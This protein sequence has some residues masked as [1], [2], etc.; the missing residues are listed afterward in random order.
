MQIRQIPFFDD[1]AAMRLSWRCSCHV[2]LQAS[3]I[4]RRVCLADPPVSG[5]GPSGKPKHAGKHDL[6]LHRSRRL[7]VGSAGK[8]Y[9]SFG[10]CQGRLPRRGSDHRSESTVDAAEQRAASCSRASIDQLR[11]SNDYVS[12]D[13]CPGN[14]SP[15]QQGIPTGCAAS[16][17]ARFGEPF[18]HGRTV[19][20]RCDVTLDRRSGCHR[21]SDSWPRTCSPPRF[22]NTSATLGSDRSPELASR[23]RLQPRPDNTRHSCPSGGRHLDGAGAYPRN[24]CM[25]K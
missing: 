7:F 6:F 16:L 22:G 21:R 19:L 25:P 13:S 20:R 11:P 17:R 24:D 8:Q 1:L 23:G 15:Q 14:H 18:S 10:H 12:I 9:R 2:W 5:G 4:W 3:C